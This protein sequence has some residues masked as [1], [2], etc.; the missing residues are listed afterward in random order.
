MTPPNVTPDTVTAWAYWIGGILSAALAAYLKIIRPQIQEWRRAMAGMNELLETN[1][2]VL[3]HTDEI[4]AVSSQIAQE[5]APNDG[6]TIRDTLTRLE[7]ASVL[8]DA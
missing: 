5:L 2:A 7:Y 4:K 1:K 6:R 8:R 3:V